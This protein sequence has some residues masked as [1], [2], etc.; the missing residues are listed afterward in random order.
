MKRNVFPFLANST[1]QG[2]S[3]LR[4]RGTASPWVGVLALL[5]LVCLPLSPVLAA[6]TV[7][8][9]D[10]NTGTTGAQDGAGTWDAGI[11]ANWWNGT[12]DVVWPNSITSTANIGTNSGAAGT[13][14]ISGSP[15]VNVINFAAPGSGTY[16][17]SGG[18]LA[19][20]GTTPTISI[21]ASQ[22]PTINSVIGETAANTTV[23]FAAT[24]SGSG[25]ITVGGA[26]TFTGAASIQA[27][28]VNFNA[29]AN[30]GTASS[31]G[32][33]ANTVGVIVGANASAAVA[34]YTGSGGS[35]DRPWLVGGSGSGGSST[36]NNNGTGAISFNN[37]GNAMTGTA[38]A[39]SLTLGGSYT[40]AA[41]TFAGLLADTTG[42]TTVLKVGGNTWNIT[43]ANTHSGGTTLNTG[44]VLN[45]GNA[46]AL[47]TGTFTVGGSGSFDDATGSDVT[48]ANAFTLSGG[49]P[50]YLGS[51]HNFTINGPVTLSGANR[52]ITVSANTLTLGGQIT[53]AFTL[54]K[55]GS[56]TLVLNNPGTAD[57]H[58]GTTINAGTLDLGGTTQTLGAVTFDT[59]GTYKVQNGTIN[60]S[61]YLSKVSSG[62]AATVSANLNGTG[63]SLNHSAGTGML[64]LLG[65][66]TFDGGVT[67]GAS[68]VTLMITNDAGLG[69]AG[70]GVTF[71][72][73]GTLAV[74]NLGA[75]A[76]NAV[77]IGS[78][79]TITVS[80]GTAS[81][82][83]A[84]T[85]NLTVAAKITGAGA[86]QKPSTSFS[87][88]TVR[89]SNDASDYTGDFSTGFGNTEFTSVANQGTASSLGAGAT[90]TG[91]Q[92][93][94][95][96]ST[97]FGTLRY[98]GAG[99]SSTMRPLNW[100]STTGSYA[101]DVTNTGTIA[102][103]A[104]GN[105]KSGSGS[106]ALTLQGSNA[107]TNTLAQ[108]VNDSGGTTSL[109]KAGTG[110]WV[111]TGANTY[112]GPTTISG[113]TLLVNG[114]IDGAG[115]TN[116]GG[117]LGG[118]GT[119]TS[120]V[121]IQSG[122]TL[123]PGQGGLDAGTLT[124]NN[125]LSL[126][127]T[128]L[129]AL[130][131]A[132][133]QNASQIAGITTLT[134]DGTLTVTNVGPA[135][136]AGD[137]FTLFSAASASGNF[138]ATNLPALG[139]ALCWRT[140]NNFAALTVNQVVAGNV[141]YTRAKGVSVKIA[142]ADLLTNVTS[143]PITGD[144]FTLTA[145]GASTNGSAIASDTLPATSGYIFF[146]PTNDLAETFTYTVSDAQGGSATGLITINVVPGAG[147][148]QS[149]T[150][151]G[152]VATVSFAGIPGYAYLVQRSTN[153]ADWV[154]LLTTNAP[155]N[156]L[157]MFADDFSDLP[158]GPP[159]SAYYRTAQP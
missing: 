77:T 75:A 57:T 136:Q 5:A 97:S 154:T 33:G 79:R 159:V 35:T 28:T 124:I 157:F 141:S 158:G 23:K 74:T 98:V 43:G 135:L 84:D 2:N 72:A 112:T 52:T 66:N 55:T 102:Y 140:T 31:F 9:W 21:A 10:A 128:T 26:N 80:S 54:T 34:S 46:T 105:L 88:G 78:S 156:G 71:S 114:S 107:G 51:A 18:T 91:G 11:T 62:N 38:G 111:L 29:L 50:T 65:N 121:T 134:V 53:G 12:A 138:S 100:T 61:S 152:G 89:F 145:V 73:S 63:V 20:G 117:T 99:N 3:C 149:I 90:G 49:S 36:I 123:Q 7:V 131:R 113:G 32:Q 4:E 153:L 22:T 8:T 95:A 86:V 142:I 1:Q 45:V 130:N 25:N 129:I 30:G 116:A 118:S 44:G 69:N 58:N 81:F 94:I 132:N 40:G 147:G 68:G 67:L 85:N 56:G 143:L 47:G 39:R 110:K 148:P 48:V 60:A 119:I 93:T 125:T 15:I 103:L 104:T 59:G 6:N 83:T 64:A 37:T 115:V 24:S 82:K 146:T 144:A 70:A 14:T 127:G 87:L 101:L 13:L 16:T 17:L 139:G 76:N 150:V 106:A 109:T 92:I 137:T 151:S 126:A 27:A 96:N 41:N 19:M 108:A 120:P 133:A 155:A 122:G 42:F